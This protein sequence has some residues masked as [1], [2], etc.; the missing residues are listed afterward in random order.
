MQLH[1][2]ELSFTVLHQSMACAAPRRAA[3]TPSWSLGSDLDEKYYIVPSMKILILFFVKIII[4][5][6]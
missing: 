2:I 6:S 4:P 1:C 3:V 5:S